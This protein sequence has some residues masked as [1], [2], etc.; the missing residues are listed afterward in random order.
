LTALPSL[1]IMITIIA[2]N[3]DDSLI[4]GE[5]RRPVEEMDE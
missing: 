5:H 3:N 4:R 1:T 2:D